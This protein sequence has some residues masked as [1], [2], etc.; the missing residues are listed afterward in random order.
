MIKLYGALE[1]PIASKELADTAEADRMWALRRREYEGIALM[2]NG[3]ATGIEAGNEIAK[4]RA[5][6]RGMLGG[7]ERFI[8]LGGNPGS[9]DFGDPRFRSLMD[10]LSN[11]QLG[12][13]LDHGF[14][15]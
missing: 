3:L 7:F 4:M 6:N 5:H 2:M 13:L 14:R 15:P 10:G 9:V 11:R 1:V 8:S 12:R